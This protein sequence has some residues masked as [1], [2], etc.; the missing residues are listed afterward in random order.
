MAAFQLTH[1]DIE[2]YC[3]RVQF[4]LSAASALLRLRESKRDSENLKYCI[5]TFTDDILV[6]IRSLRHSPEEE[7]LE[8]LCQV[9]SWNE[10][11]EVRGQKESRGGHG[12]VSGL[13]DVSFGRL[14]EE[15]CD[16]GDEDPLGMQWQCTVSHDLPPLSCRE[17]ITLQELDTAIGELREL[18]E[19]GVREIRSR[20]KWER[21]QLLDS[22]EKESPS[23]VSPAVFAALDERDRQLREGTLVPSANGKPAG[24]IRSWWSIDFEDPRKDHDWKTVNEIREDYGLSELS[25]ERVSNA[26][27]TWGRDN[28]GEWKPSSGSGNPHRYRPSSVFTVIETCQ[29]KAAANENYGNRN[30]KKS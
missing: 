26:L 7:I 15:L 27:I 9:I 24:N 29:R 1:A 6:S 19:L 17:S 28:Q 23:N 5:E 3:N 12:Y 20:L 18:D 2:H 22:M 11:L 25:R 13:L 21:L 16:D 10:L 30:P 14:R 8:R 4:G